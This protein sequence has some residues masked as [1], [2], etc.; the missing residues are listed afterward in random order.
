MNNLSFLYPEKLFLLIP[1]AVFFLFLLFKYKPTKLL[2]LALNFFAVVLGVFALAGLAKKDEIHSADKVVAVDISKSMTKELKDKLQ[3]KLQSLDLTDSLSF[4]SFA[5]S[6]GENS[7]I[8]S[9][10]YE[11]LLRAFPDTSLILLSDGQET[12]GNILHKLRTGALKSGKIYP[13][14]TDEKIKLKT[15]IKIKRLYVPL[16]FDAGKKTEIGLSI[17][18][19]SG[20]QINTD[21]TVQQNGKNLPNRKMNLLSGDTKVVKIETEEIRDGLNEFMFK[22]KDAELH[23]FITGKKL[24]KVLVLSSG[25]YESKELSK[26]LKSLKFQVESKVGKVSSEINFQDYILVIFNNIPLSFLPGNAAKELENY[27]QT[28]GSFLMLGGNKSFG[29]GDYKDTLIEDLLPVQLLEP[30]KVQKRLN[31]AVEL[32]LDKSGSMKNSGKISFTKLAAEGVIGALKDEDYIGIIGF[33]SQPFIAF[34]VSLLGNGGRTKALKRIN[35]LFPNGSTN[36]YPAMDAARI[37]IERARAG[38]KHMIILTDGRLPDEGGMSA[39]YLKMAS[40]LKGMGIT[41]ST[42]LIGPDDSRLLQEIAENGGGK[43]HRTMDA[44]TLPRLFLEDVKV[45]TSEQTQKEYENYRVTREKVASPVATTK[46]FKNLQGYVATKEKPEATTELKI[47]AEES[48]DPLLAYWNYKEGKVVAYTSDVA[49]RWSSEWYQSDYYRQFWSDVLDYLVDSRQQNIFTDF[50]F[51]YFFHA[52]ELSFELTV[53][54]GGFKASD[55]KAKI[56]FPDNTESDLSFVSKAPGLF[57]DSL[58]IKTSGIATLELTTPDEKVHKFKIDLPDE[59]IEE[60][61]QGVNQA[62]LHTLAGLTGGVVNPDKKDFETQTITKDSYQ[63]LTQPLLIGSL[64]LLLLSIL[65]RNY[66]V[67]VA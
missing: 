56:I 48:E 10:N 9:T 39:Y 19:F 38:K 2:S 50:D 25:E 35:L 40:Q 54:Q 58:N 60:T 23:Y 46:Y 17:E 63:K 53:Y 30:K 29:L 12:A 13:I 32:V 21:L 41:V 28:G 14:I 3:R 55:F 45:N 31:V 4:V 43:F 26:L 36:L 44:Q 6:L 15:G 20:S 61:P 52:N 27:I 65:L 33:D 7:S 8:Q 51:N 67:A 24:P 62:F 16:I 57:T 66:R 34:N 11:N 47:V 5:D 64:V 59:F 18:N 1:I 22:L 37:E 49:K 42:F